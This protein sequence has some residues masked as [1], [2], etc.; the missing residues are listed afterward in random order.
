MRSV[1]L[2]YYL[3]LRG[4]SK[5][6]IDENYLD[7]LEGVIVDKNYNVEMKIN[8][9]SI[10]QDKMYRDGEVIGQVLDIKTP[11]QMQD[12]LEM[13]IDSNYS[14]YLLETGDWHIIPIENL[15]AKFAKVDV[16]LMATASVPNHINLLS[17]IL[18]LGVN[19]CLIQLG[20]SFDLSDFLDMVEVD[21]TIDLVE[22]EVCSIDRIGAG[23]RVCVDTCS[24]LKKGEGLL[25]GSSAH[26]MCLIE[27]EV[28]ES[29]FVNARPFRVNAGVIASY[30]LI[31]EK[32]SYLSEITAGSNVM[33]VDRKGNTRKECVA[34]VKIERRPMI[35][36]KVRYENSEYSIILQDAETVKMVT[37]EASIR[38]DQLSV[39]DRV[40]GQISDKA[41][42]FGMAINETIEEK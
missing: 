25:I 37:N 6:I 14:I 38:V 20:D 26:V 35:H 22:L 39:G 8:T 10:I 30:T 40:L 36:I 33:I 13:E 32:T 16:E 27:A 1:P 15:I 18:E 17:N 2:R 29:G 41:R 12:I 4:K 9:I 3:D 11:E 7:K 31:Q 5:L 28:E 21:N 23:D 42:H 19:S 24:I 34:R